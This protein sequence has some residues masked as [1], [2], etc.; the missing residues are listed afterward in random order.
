[1][2]SFGLG[3]YQQGEKNC[4]EESRLGIKRVAKDR[5]RKR[6]VECTR[7]KKLPDC[8]SE[9]SI[10][11]LV[12]RWWSF[13]VGVQH[14]KKKAHIAQS[15]VGDMGRLKRSSRVVV[16]ARSRSHI[17]NGCHQ[18][19]NVNFIK[20]M[21]S[22]SAQRRIKKK[23]KGAT[24]HLGYQE[25]KRKVLCFVFLSIKS[26]AVVHELIALSKTFLAMQRNNTGGAK[27]EKG[28]SNCKKEESEKKKVEKAE[29]P[30][31]KGPEKRKRR[32]IEQI[33]DQD[34]GNVT[35]NPKGFLSTSKRNNVKTVSLSQQ[36][37]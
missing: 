7:D 31:I 21:A 28:L 3:L 2:H 36:T 20:I 4:T 10:L 13:L 33:V 14:R 9:N 34:M 11:V 29:K 22:A 15:Q 6:N 35:D 17:E 12:K 37:V 1:M 24:R 26:E 23:A 19:S 30:K 18:D 27:V 25:K 16:M 32:R 5:N 8:L